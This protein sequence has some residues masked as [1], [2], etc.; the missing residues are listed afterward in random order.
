MEAAGIEG[1][2]LVDDVGPLRT[3][4]SE[5]IPPG[6]AIGGHQLGEVLSVRGVTT[7]Q[8]DGDR[9]RSRF[10]GAWYDE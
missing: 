8:H 6:A 4:G 5:T 7:A 9:P 2:T 10:A 1:R 3:D